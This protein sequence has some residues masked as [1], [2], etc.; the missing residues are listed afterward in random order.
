MKGG[1]CLYEDLNEIYHYGIK[2]MKWGI[3]RTPE[4]L[5]YKP[6]PKKPKVTPEE[7]QK[8]KL[9]KRQQKEALKTYK[10]KTKFEKEREQVLRSPSKLYKN[11]DKFTKE[12]I[13]A[14]M[15]RFKWEQELRNMS[16]SDMNRGKEYLDMILGYTESG[17]KAYNTVA[18]LYNTFGGVEEKDKMKM[19]PGVGGGDKKKK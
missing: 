14:A 12:E 6:K 4:Q 10:A 9:T 1:I 19:I 8:K 13:D 2:G 17:M 16:K 18:R 15:R 3:R 11:R 7:K 5:G